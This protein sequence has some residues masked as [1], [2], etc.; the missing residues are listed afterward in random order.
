MEFAGEVNNLITNPRNISGEDKDA[1]FEMLEKREVKVEEFLDMLFLRYTSKKH[2][3]FEQ[4]F[5][6]M[7]KEL[8]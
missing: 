4:Y 6:E 7:D 8:Q 2:Q 1:L 3:M 5:D